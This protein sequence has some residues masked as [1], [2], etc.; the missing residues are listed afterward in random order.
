MGQSG[1][2]HQLVHCQPQRHRTG[3]ADRLLG[4]FQQLT[5][6]AGAVDQA[7]AVLVGALVVALQQQEHGNREGVGCIAVDD[8]EPG[9]L[10][11]QGGISVYR[12]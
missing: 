7:A 10:C 3:I 4:V 9:L 11:P 8:I 6:E 5:Q 2:T 12:I 1:G